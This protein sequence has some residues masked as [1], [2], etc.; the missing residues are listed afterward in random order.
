MTIPHTCHA[1]GCDER[2]PRS[3]FMCR[4]H[5]FMV[6]KRMRNQIWATYVPGQELT[7]DPSP[8]YLVATRKAIDY[9][10]RKEEAVQ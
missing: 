6:P 8:Q 3:M 10:A 4:R 2:T 7:M 5:W 9:V 1:R